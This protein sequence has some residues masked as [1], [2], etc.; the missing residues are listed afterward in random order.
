MKLILN[1]VRKT[2]IFFSLYMICAG[3]AFYQISI[4]TSFFAPA[5][6]PY[7][8]PSHLR[9]PGQTHVD[10]PS[11]R[12]HTAAANNNNNN[13]ASH[14]LDYEGCNFFRQRLVLS[15]LSG[16]RVKIKGIRSRDDEPGLRGK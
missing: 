4:A 14:G 9:L 11:Q 13:M 5:G 12:R 6:L 1:Y 15:T 16:K 8:A 7:F 3:F 10:S 2:F